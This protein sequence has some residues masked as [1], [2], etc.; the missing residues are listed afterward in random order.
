MADISTAAGVS[1][2]IVYRHFDSKDALYKAVLER[3]IQQLDAALGAP[4]AIGRYGITPR[5]L[6]EN[7]RA[8]PDAFRVLW[9]HAAR[10]PAFVGIV[11]DARDRLVRTTRD[12]LADRRRAVAAAVGRA[13]HRRV[14]HR[15]GAR[16]DRRR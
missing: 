11:D 13:G 12:A 1:H 5:A 10:E 3:A 8:A 15:I 16:V 4:G 7:A 2:L 6:L 14:S 9:R